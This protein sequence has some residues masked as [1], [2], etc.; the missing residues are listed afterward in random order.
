MARRK[1]EY[2]DITGQNEANILQSLRTAKQAIRDKNG[3]VICPS[4]SAL[5]VWTQAVQGRLILFGYMFP[6]ESPVPVMQDKPKGIRKPPP[7]N[8][9]LVTEEEYRRC[10]NW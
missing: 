1:L 9:G 7:V 8:G 6:E 5:K 4:R 3:K 10:L 2:A